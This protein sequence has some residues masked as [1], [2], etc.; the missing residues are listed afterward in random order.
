MSLGLSR[1]A[2]LAQGFVGL[3]NELSWRWKLKRPNI[4]KTRGFHMTVNFQPVLVKLI[5]RANESH[6]VGTVAHRIISSRLGWAEQRVVLE[7][8]AQT[9]KRITNL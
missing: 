5:V 9:S 4:Q 8:E 2:S 7:M 3:N 6:D 1:T